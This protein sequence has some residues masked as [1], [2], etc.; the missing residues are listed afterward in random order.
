MATPHV[1]GAIAL[2]KHF[3]RLEGS[4]EYTPQE[5]E[6]ALNDSGLAIYDSGSGVAY[7][8]IDVLE[9]LR[10]I[11]AS[12]PEITMNSPSD[13]SLI[14]ETNQT[15]NCSVTDALQ[16]SN[17]TFRLYNI[18]GE[19]FNETTE[20][21]TSNTLEF[22]INI[23]LENGTYL[24]NCESYDNKSNTNS[25]GNYTLKIGSMSISLDSPSDEYYDDETS[26]D[27][28]CSVENSVSNLT[29][30]TF[31]LWNSSGDLIYNETENISGTSNLSVFNYTF[32]SEM[33]YEWNCEAY[34]D[35]G[36]SISESSNY[37]LTY[38]DTNPVVTLVDPE[39]E[40]EEEEGS[41]TFS[42]NVTD[43]STIDNC[44]LIIDDVMEEDDTTVDRDE[45]ETF[46]TSL[47]DGNYDWEVQ[48]RDD[49]GNVGT[50]DTWE[51][52]VTA[53]S[54]DDDDDGG[55]S[56]P[57]GGSPGGA[58]AFYITDS[59]LTA[60]ASKY[61]RVGDTMKFNLS[62]DEHTLKVDSY[63]EDK[64]KVTISSDTITLNIDV[65]GVEKADLDNDNVYD[66]EVTY[67]EYV[68]TLAKVQIKKISE[69]APVRT[70]QDT[71]STTDAPESNETIGTEDEAVNASSF[72]FAGKISAVWEK[73]GKTG[74]IIFY[75][76][77][78]A[79]L[80]LVL[81]T[82]AYFNKERIMAR[83]PRVDVSIKKRR[84]SKKQ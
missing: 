5:V 84:F 77:L 25:S 68:N 63:G 82:I 31:Y 83:L 18:T 47:E 45:T 32:S 64:V 12:A 72:D 74:H 19:L 54:D 20:N 53:D 26:I 8:R 38:D 76:G 34:D 16:L 75:I 48:C 35:D 7:S 51:L 10:T 52:D 39:D 40:G 78:G 23:T 60:G 46:S 17:V 70:I 30:M 55:G 41:I 50:S 4:A 2:V 61:M 81:G 1:S 44:S 65:G 69:A 33:E 71:P 3:R 37:T 28:N 22:T 62:G 15:F 58:T 66:L 73:M 42:Y 43:G 59:D 11:D 36:N 9:T 6:D 57:S 49:A 29:N 27:F 80:I 21:A 67:L 24:W 14:A 13:D 56:S 79:V